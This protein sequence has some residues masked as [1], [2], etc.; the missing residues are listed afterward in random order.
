MSEHFC[1]TLIAKK[2]STTKE[3]IKKKLAEFGLFEGRNTTSYFGNKEVLVYFGSNE[4]TN[5]IELTIAISEQVFHKQK[6]NEELK[7]FTTFFD[8]C[9]KS[10]NNLLFALCSYELNGY[11]LSKVNNLQDFD[12]KLLGNFPLV[13]KRNNE[14]SLLSLILNLQAQNIF[15][16]L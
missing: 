7:I 15:S 3:K 6:L 9:F 10:C 8:S 14:E 1:I 12:L 2:S 13:Y 16:I 5:F 4:E 11:L